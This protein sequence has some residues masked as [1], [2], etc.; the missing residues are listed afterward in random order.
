MSKLDAEVAKEVMGLSVRGKDVPR[1]SE[2]V[3]LSILVL[4][5]IRCNGLRILLNMD[6]GGFHLRRVVCVQHDGIRKEAVY[7]ADK[8]LGTAS[9]LSALPEMICKA[10]L[11]EVRGAKKKRP[12]R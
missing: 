1:Y 6:D 4:N 11:A 10:A 5:E 7:T 2:S 12:K 3:W 8:H 9:T